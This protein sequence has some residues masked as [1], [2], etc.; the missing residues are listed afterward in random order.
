MARAYADQEGNFY[1]WPIPLENK[2]GKPNSFVESAYR[3]ID[4]SIGKWC[5]FETN[6]TT[7][8]YELHEMDDQPPAPNW[9]DDGIEFLV[10][11]AF[12]DRIIR[13]INHP[14]LTLRSHRIG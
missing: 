2:L 9:L 14:H 7:K 4:L 6:L 8:V 5:H 13:D 3:V 11:L 10:K 12:R 1:L